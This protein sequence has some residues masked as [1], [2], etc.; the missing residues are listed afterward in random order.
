MRLYIDDSGSMSD[1]DV[2]KHIPA[3]T[4]ETFYFDTKVYPANSKVWRGGGTDFEAVVKHLE[5][6]PTE[7]KVMIITD[8]YGPGIENLPPGVVVHVLA[9]VHRIR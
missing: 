8:G 6:F 1:F 4:K 9:D 3:E 5:D 7:Q 2:D